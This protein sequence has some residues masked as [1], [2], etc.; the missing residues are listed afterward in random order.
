MSALPNKLRVGV[1][2]VGSL[3]RHHVRIYSHMQEVELVGVADTNRQ[4]AEE[5]AA[6]YHTKAW[7]DFEAFVGHV[8]AISLAVPTVEHARIGCHLLREGIDLLVEKPIASS[9]AEAD[10][11]IRTA[12]AHQRVLQVGHVERFNP[13]VAAARKIIKGPKFFEI[14][15][16]S[17]FTPRSLDIDVV[18]DL[19]I[20][21]LDILLAM[22]DADV[23]DI[24]AVGL[25]I[26]TPKV[27]IA[28]VRIEFA[29]G[30]VAN[31]TASRVSTE[32][33]R[34]LR[35]FQPNEYISIDYSRQQMLVLKLD[36]DEN[37]EL[38]IDGQNVSGPTE[39]PLKLEL[40]SFVHAVRT[41]ST[42]QVTGED[43]RR[44]LK[45]AE[46]IVQRIEAH[47]KIALGTA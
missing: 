16:L 43:G 14:H 34:K 4:R 44:A 47:S 1:V 2:G 42:P 5:L 46:E 29:N 24:R 39:E 11:L 32:K 36:R 18:L 45:V 10:A 13:A 6:A 9:L 7:K 12:H 20:H 17:L 27:D 3:G 8:D 35:F 19:M 33:V 26:L 21:D 41:H 25:P 40:E 15:R 22:V 37:G 30:C 31:L 28:N 38:K 23:T